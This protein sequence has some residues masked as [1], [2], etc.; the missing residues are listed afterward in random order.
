VSQVIYRGQRQ[1]RE[2]YGARRHAYMEQDDQQ[3]MIFER[4][5]SIDNL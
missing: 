1:G 5:D 4:K 3:H 2:D